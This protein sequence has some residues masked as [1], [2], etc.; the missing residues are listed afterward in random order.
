M[1][2]AGF[3]WERNAEDAYV[4]SCRALDRLVRDSPAHGS[5]LLEVLSNVHC[6]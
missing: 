4:F 1:S 5:D 6:E 2:V 3:D